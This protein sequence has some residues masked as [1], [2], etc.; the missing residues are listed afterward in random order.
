M[1]GLI[2]ILAL[3]YILYPILFTKFQPTNYLTIFYNSEIGCYTINHF[4]I[5]IGHGLKVQHFRMNS[6]CGVLEELP[7]IDVNLQY[8]FDYQQTVHLPAERTVLPVRYY[9]CFQ[10][11]NTLKILLSPFH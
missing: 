7:P 10:A 2:K 4:V 6:E 5:L 1:L 8:D 11:L 9:T 3:T